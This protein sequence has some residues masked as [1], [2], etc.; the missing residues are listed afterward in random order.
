MLFT[1]YSNIS[2]PEIV[3]EGFTRSISKF[4]TRTSTKDIDEAF[5]KF[6]YKDQLKYLIQKVIKDNP[7][8]EFKN[9]IIDAKKPYSVDYNGYCLLPKL[10]NKGE[11]EE[12]IIYS[13]NKYHH[14]EAKIEFHEHKIWDKSNIPKPD[15]RMR[16]DP[17]IV[18]QLDNLFFEDGYE[19][20]IKINFRGKKYDCLIYVEDYE[21]FNDIYGQINH[22]MYDEIRYDIDRELTDD[23]WDIVR[24]QA[25]DFLYK[26]AKKSA[27]KVEN[28]KLGKQFKVKYTINKNGNSG[29]EV[30]PN[31][32]K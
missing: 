15:S 9:S 18:D 24:S 12:I 25:R 6:Q 7:R 21:Y 28:S 10:D 20:H 32:R 1:K 23:D 5:K 14:N 30:T 8:E 11:I 4:I 17:D 27:Q 2:I 13:I 31:Y 22:L 3:E 19:Y 16:L 29:V 26:L